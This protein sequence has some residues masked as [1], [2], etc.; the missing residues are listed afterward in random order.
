[1]SKGT[2]NRVMIIGNV[3]KDPKFIESGEGI[4]KLSLATTEI[5]KDKT[6][7]TE[8]HNVTVFG[9]LS[10]IVRDY[11]TK[12]A[13]VFVEGRLHLNKWT[14]KEGKEHL[15]TDIIAHSLQVLN[16]NKKTEDQLAFDTPGTKSTTFDDCDIPF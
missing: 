6:E 7:K 12:G 10:G 11:V 15:S 9:K 3:G 1:M 8:W 2:L 16:W 14:D 4:A 13:K 5:G